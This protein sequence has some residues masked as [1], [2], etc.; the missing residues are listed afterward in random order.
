LA[1]PATIHP[2][3]VPPEVLSRDMVVMGA[4]TLSLFLF[5]YGPRGGTH[6]PLEG[7]VLLSVF[8]GYTGWLA[9]TVMAVQA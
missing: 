8:I 3:A 4:L 7:G 1:S 9:Y 6:Q 5:A 2:M